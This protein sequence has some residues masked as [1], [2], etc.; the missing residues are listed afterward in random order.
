MFTLSG[1]IGWVGRQAYLNVNPVSLCEGWQLMAEA[2]T[3]D[4]SNP[5]DLGIPTLFSLHH[6]HLTSAIGI[7]PHGQQNTKMQ[8]NNRK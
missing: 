1:A 5:G 3:N 6:Y 7:S 4:A 2:I 8:L